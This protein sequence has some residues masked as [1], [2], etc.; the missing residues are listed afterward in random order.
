[1]IGKFHRI[2]L[3]DKICYN[4]SNANKNNEDKKMKKDKI[5]IRKA[6]SKNIKSMSLLKKDK[7][8]VSR[9]L[10]E[11]SKTFTAL[12]EYDKKKTDQQ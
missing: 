9:L 12:Y 1:M 8:I 2:V 3:C 7:Q 10:S 5:I 6:P 11:Y 4:G